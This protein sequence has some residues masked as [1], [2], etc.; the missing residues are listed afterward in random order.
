MLR[1]DDF[2]R[3]A[4]SGYAQGQLVFD[5]GFHIGDDSAGYLS[6]G[7][8]VVAV[9]ANGALVE[10]GRKRFRNEVASGQL[11]ILN[12][13]MWHTSG[14]K[15][16]FCINETYPGMSTIDRDHCDRV[17]GKC[18]EVE[19]ETVTVADLFETYGTP[20]YMK[21]DIEAADEMVV[22]S[23]PEGCPLPKYFSCEIS[24][25]S[26]M[27]GLLSTY[28]YVAFKLINQGTLTQSLPIFDNEFFLRALRKSS[29]ICPPVR[30]LIAG[31]PEGIRPKKI[32][33]DP[34]RNRFSPQLLRTTGPFGE[35]ADG[36]WQSTAEMTRHI[37]YVYAQY[38]RSG[39][40][41]GF[42][43]DLHA[44]HA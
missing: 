12:V 29:V 26:P 13:A 9:E 32:L 27:V 31:L 39:L 3:N 14:A 7:Y 8:R 38:V 37:D 20:W 15:I 16:T 33:W 21:M 28:G 4:G 19:V 10:D 35:E 30:S 17:G 18:H 24:H 34:P 44:R 40:V 1:S 36:K 2:R 6:R 22:R 5:I 43:Y 11:T 42:W 41:N 25:G 23:L